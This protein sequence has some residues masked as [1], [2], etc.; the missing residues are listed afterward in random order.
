MNSEYL[1]KFFRNLLLGENNELRNTFCHIKGE[2]LPVNGKNL[3]VNLSVNKTQERILSLLIE[4][5]NYTYS[6]L[7]E[8]TGKTR[9]TIRVNLAIWKRWV[10]SSVLALTR[11]VIG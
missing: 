5:P 6:D 3:P 1:E 4:N 9:E 2:N 8:R 10:R 11:M 7:A